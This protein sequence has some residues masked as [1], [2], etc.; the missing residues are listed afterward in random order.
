MQPN[1]SL[2]WQSQHCCYP[3][4]YN[5]AQIKTLWRQNYLITSKAVGQLRLNRLPAGKGIRDALHYK[6]QVASG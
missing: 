5:L 3:N 1:F 6:G 2:G 4:A